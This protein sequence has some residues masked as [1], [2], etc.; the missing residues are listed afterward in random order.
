M[1]LILSFKF[2]EVKWRINAVY[3]AKASAQYIV[4]GKPLGA[5]FL[6]ICLSSYLTQFP[7]KS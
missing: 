7:W 2:R 4:R 6:I 3:S 5:L 1:T